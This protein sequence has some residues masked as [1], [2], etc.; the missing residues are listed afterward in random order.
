MEIYFMESTMSVATNTTGS[1]IALSQEQISQIQP[2]LK[3]LEANQL[4]WLSGYIAGMANGHQAVAQTEVLAQ[5]VVT[6]LYASQTGNARGV[7]EQLKL[8]LSNKNLASEIFTMG[9]YRLKQLKKA[10]WLVVIASTQGNGEPPEEAIDF[11]EQ[12]FS[13]RAA[14]LPDV[15]YS[16]VGLG[17][18]SY[19]FFCHI[20]KEIDA[21]L[22]SLGAKRFL[23]RLDCDLDYEDA[24]SAWESNFI[25]EITPKLQT[26]A[27]V[28]PII[29]SQASISKW[30]KS[31]P[32]SAEL[33]TNQKITGRTSEQ[34]VRHV[35]ISLEDSGLSY[36]PGDALGIKAKNSSELVK[37]ILDELNINLETTLGQDFTNRNIVDILVNDYEL[38]NL[39][40]GFLKSWAELGEIE[41]LINISKE[42]LNKYLADYQIIDVI[43]E[44]SVVATAEQFISYLRKL[45]PRLYSIS[46]SSDVYE[47]EVHITVAK[48]EYE[49]FGFKHGGHAST[50]VIDQVNIDDKID[51]YI[52]ENPNFRLP[53]TENVPIIMIGAG[54]GVAPYRAFL[55]QRKSNNDQGDNWLFFGARHFHSDFLYQEELVNY[56]DKGLLTNLDV[57]F[58]R[59]QEH[60]IYVQHLIEKQGTEL[61]QWLERGAHVYVCGALHMASDIHDALLNII[62]LN[63]D[64]SLVDAQKYMNELRKA[65]RYQKDVY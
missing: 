3:E 29:N 28:I 46:S 50:Y 2:V 30:N 34:D 32:F 47:D 24:V 23:S 39:H 21:R 11:Y 65:K 9:D 22:E 12:L 56:R 64:C 60:K 31:N 61:F 62:Q 1:K 59:D 18:S 35:E 10:T 7:A 36:R 16:I 15:N 37:L 40:P 33:I 44:F 58:S 27:N 13:Q 53:V 52:A 45:T 57:A 4:I 20:G 48:V 8:N 54:T 5:E 41:K 19:E 42:E 25:K 51:V 43:R 49:S 38:T 63:K 55:Q 26:T 14:K 17:D 6:I